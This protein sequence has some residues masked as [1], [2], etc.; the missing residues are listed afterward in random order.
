V[1]DFKEL[2]SD[3]EQWGL[4][5]RDFLSELGFIIDSP[6]DRGADLGKDLLVIE[7]L[8]G[9]LAKYPFKW[10]VSCKNYAVSGRSVSEE[11]EKN[12]LERIKGFHCDG[13][14]GFYSTLPS[15]GLNS[16][17]MQLKINKEIKDYKIFETDL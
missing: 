10:L 2:D 17:L 6:P 16:R 8:G 5:A 13:F 4:F 3:G 12:I 14:I 15:A 7:N 1:I 11:D 9:L